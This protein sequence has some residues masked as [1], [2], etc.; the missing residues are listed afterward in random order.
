MNFSLKPQE[1]NE[2]KNG[3]VIAILIENKLSV[4]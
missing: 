3:E 4:K 1:I 2:H